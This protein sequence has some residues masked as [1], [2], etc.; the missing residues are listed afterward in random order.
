[1]DDAHFTHLLKLAGVNA[2]DRHLA[3][4][5]SGHSRDAAPLEEHERRRFCD[6]DLEMALE[7]GSTDRLLEL[8]LRGA[9]RPHDG[10]VLEK[11]KNAWMAQVQVS[12][13][14]ER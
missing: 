12:G 8:K 9:A 6:R 4:V 14:V 10:T 3:T 7:P 1:M 13:H 11:A 5:L 2:A